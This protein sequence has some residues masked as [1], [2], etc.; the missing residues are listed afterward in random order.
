MP[1]ILAITFDVGS[2][3][4]DPHPSV[5]HV[6]AEVAALHGHPGLSPELL[7]QHFH[8]AFKSYPRPLHT[9]EDWAAVVD[10]TFA[11]FVSPP[12]SRTF[13]P[14]L[15]ER[16][17][18]PDAWH[19][20]DDVLPTLE[21]LRRRA[22]RLAIISN[23]DGRLRPLLHQLGLAQCFDPI[24]VSCEQGVPKPQ[25]EI[26]RRAAALLGL[27]SSAILHVGDSD[28]LDAAGARQAGFNAILL[29]R[30]QPAIPG[31]RVA[32]LRELPSLLSADPS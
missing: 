6:Y 32:S 19:I 28:E 15:Y 4:I 7:N 31:Q 26:F 10:L 9:A 30:Q 18:Q 24:V 23:W 11:P 25:P 20:Y 27:P 2:T 3:L 17:A 22:L 14:Q 16:F 1:P 13:F 21:R 5:G 8:R 12:P 29:D